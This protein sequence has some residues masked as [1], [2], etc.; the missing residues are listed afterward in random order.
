MQ[1]LGRGARF[2]RTVISNLRMSATGVVLVVVRSRSLDEIK[3][4]FIHSGHY[5]CRHGAHPGP[6]KERGVP[7]TQQCK[8]ED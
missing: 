3:G 5:A 6:S 8:N 7:L 4:L 2:A 1:E